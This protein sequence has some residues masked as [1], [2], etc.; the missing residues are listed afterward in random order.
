[1]IVAGCNEFKSCG[2]GFF[3][4]WDA[5]EAVG[6]SADPVAVADSGE[7]ALF[8]WGQYAAGRW[9]TWD[10]R[11]SRGAC[12]IAG[13]WVGVGERQNSTQRAQRLHGESQRRLSCGRVESLDCDD[14]ISSIETAGYVGEPW[15]RL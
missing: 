4:W 14:E 13:F 9:G 10:G 1:M 12:G 15:S 5:V 11:V 8:V 6:I 2:R 7:G 3:G